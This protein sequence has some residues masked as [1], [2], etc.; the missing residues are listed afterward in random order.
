MGTKRPRPSKPASKRGEVLV[1]IMNNLADWEIVKSQLW[2]RVPVD[3]APKRWPPQ[4]LAFYQT[5]V[6]KEE[7]FA[8]RYFAKVRMIRRV[9]RQDLFPNEP[10]NHKSNREYYQVFLD[11]LEKLAIPIVS[12]R[13][14]RVSFIPTTWHK[15]MAAEEINDLFDESPL[16][17]ALWTEMKKLDMRAERQYYLEHKDE[18]F[19]LDFALF[20]Q[21]GK[22]DV[23]T[24]GDT[25][26]AD[27]ER[28]PE[29]NRRNNALASLGWHVLRFN[30]SEVRETRAEYC[31]PQIVTTVNKLGGLD[32]SAGEP[33]VYRAINGG[34]AQQFSLF[35]DDGNE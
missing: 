15:L 30:T 22:L 8:I 14:R 29:D 10:Q 35:G 11:G 7:A 6:F 4:W 20:C 9:S 28:I 18:W 16:E 21:S 34:I 26:H 5:K 33:R 27:P 19:A 32:E 2:Y 31:V 17:D 1:A 13:F 3:K 12:Y 23:E 25:W 24:D